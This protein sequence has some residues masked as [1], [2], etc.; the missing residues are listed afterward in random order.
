MENLS[1]EEVKNKC[2]NRLMEVR[3]NEKDEHYY[4]SLNFFLDNGFYY[5]ECWNLDIT[6]SALILPRLIQFKNTQVG[7]PPSF[8]NGSLLYSD[9]E[10]YKRKCEKEALK[11]WN[12]VL[13][14]MIFAFKSIVYSDEEK[15]KTGGE[16]KALSE[17][18][19]LGLKLFG[20]YFRCLWD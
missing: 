9:N 4:D 20:K 5:E 3:T 7:Y 6:L 12:D 2:H 1:L 16:R 17:K 10:E 13:D 19:D 15:C 18:I 14:K 8:Y 11:E